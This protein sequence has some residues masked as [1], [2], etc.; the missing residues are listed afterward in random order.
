[1]DTE[2]TKVS[3][4]TRLAWR[5]ENRKMSQRQQ[6]VGWQEGTG[7]GRP[8]E[9]WRVSRQVVVYLLGVASQKVC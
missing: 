4:G 2:S 8:G 7:K 6:D 1:M 9:R 5:G 3:E